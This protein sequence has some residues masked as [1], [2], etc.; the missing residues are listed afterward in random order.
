MAN[1]VIRERA[2]T[3]V[4]QGQAAA[5]AGQRELARRYLQAAVDI[6]AENVEA[7]LWLA[8][9][10][11]DPAA[12]QASLERVLELEPDNKRAQQGLA[13]A[14]Q[15]LASQPEPESPEA[16]EEPAYESK[17]PSIEQT[18]RAQLRQ[19]S[20][21]DDTAGAEASHTAVS[22]VSDSGERSVTGL[23]TSEDLLFR[24][25][26]VALFG[27]LLLGIIMVVLLVLGVLPISV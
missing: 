16:Q 17:P 5:K 14:E 18:L 6:D 25:I 22:A 21:S 12:I 19:S 3:F 8:G 4:E 13:W 2:Q 24:A 9:V 10:Q 26:T 1:D 27:L 7:W 11:D 23:L 20:Q 15:Q